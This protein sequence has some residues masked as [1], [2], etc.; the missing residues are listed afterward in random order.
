MWSFLLVLGS[1]SAAR[2]PEVGLTIEPILAA[3]LARES[4]TEDLLEGWTWLNARA[5]QRLDQGMWFFAARATHSVRYG[6]DTESSWRLDVG[7]TGISGPIGPIH[8]RAGNLVERWGKLDLTPVVDVLNPRDLSAGP[9]STVEALRI[10]VPMVILQES[11]GPVRAEV[12][13]TPFPQS[14]RIQMVGSDWSLIRPGMLEGAVNEAAGWDGE[15]AALLSGQVEQLGALLNEL[16]PTT[17]RGASA[18]V[19]EME[20][21]EQTGLNGNLGLRVEVETTGLDMALMG[22]SLVSPAPVTRLSSSTLDILQGQRFPTIAEAGDLLDTPPIQTDWP[23]TAFAGAELATVLGPVGVRAEGAWWSNKVVQQTWL[24]S[25]G[26]PAAAIGGGL[27]WSH[28]S[29]LYVSIES[30]WTHLLEPPENLSMISEDTIDIGGT[31][32]ASL[33]ADRINLMAAGLLSPTFNEWM[34]RPEVQW[35][36][37]DPFQLSIGAIL[38]DGPEP[39]PVSLR[40]A[41]GYTGGP[42]T[43]FADNDLGFVSLR[44]IQ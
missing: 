25:T 1:A 31:I 36:V 30:R 14:D 13:Y 34:A 24:S 3:D 9:L 33:A 43:M 21:P 40:Q 35:R 2:P 37:S 29:S 39:S 16:S 10:P 5:K 4:D 12:S 8:G 28:G 17:L 11:A 27:D 32:R 22:A 6:E 26:T 42:L 15:S 19:G 7:E 44:W 20:R 23:R 18:V 41:L 38:I